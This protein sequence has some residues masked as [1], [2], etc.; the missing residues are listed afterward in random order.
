M[1]EDSQKTPLVTFPKLLLARKKI[2]APCQLESLW[3]APAVRPLLPPRSLLRSL[4]ALS[5]SLA[6]LPRQSRDPLRFRKEEG[7]LQ[8]H[9]TLIYLLIVMKSPTLSLRGKA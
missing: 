8:M 3:L 9:S 7:L 1:D 5:T 6:F 4:A 2:S